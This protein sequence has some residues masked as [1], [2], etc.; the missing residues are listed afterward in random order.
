M[1]FN[2]GKWFDNELSSCKFKD[3]R[4]KKRFRILIENFWNE[5]RKPIPLACQGWLTPK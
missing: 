3:E 5:V 1:D 2:D 4:I